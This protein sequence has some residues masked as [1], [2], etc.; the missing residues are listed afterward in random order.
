MQILFALK[1]VFFDPEKFFKQCLWAQQV[2]FCK[3]MQKGSPLQICMLHKPICNTLKAFVLQ[4][5]HFAIKPNS[6]CVSMAP[7]LAAIMGRSWVSKLLIYNLVPMQEAKIKPRYQEKVIPTCSNYSHL[8]PSSNSGHF[9]FKNSQAAVI[10][11]WISYIY[12]MRQ[13]RW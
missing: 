12:A 9:F 6:T 8:L 1:T 10:F 2:C 7:T 11:T 4:L 13:H 5:M 3:L